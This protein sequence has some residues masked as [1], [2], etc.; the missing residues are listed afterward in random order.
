MD[1]DKME[2]WDHLGSNDSEKKPTKKLGTAGTRGRGYERLASRCFRSTGHLR[3]FS[4]SK[5]KT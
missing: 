1:Q 3:K 5:K 2:L 4:P